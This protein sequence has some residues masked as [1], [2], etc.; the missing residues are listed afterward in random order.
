MSR[1][2]RAFVS[3][4]YGPPQPVDRLKFAVVN[5]EQRVVSTV[6]TVF[7]A[8]NPKRPDIYLTASGFHSSTKFSIHRDTL[9]HSFLAEAHAGLVERGVVAQGSRHQQQIAIPRLP[10]HG[11]TLRFV[12]ELL[13]KK[14]HSADEYKG[15]IVA[16]PV[17]PDGRVLEI[18]LLLAEGTALKVSGAQAAIGQVV[19]GGRAL[20][21]V[22]AFREHDAE[23]H[24]ADIM[25]LISRTRV[26]D[27]V[28]RNIDPDMDLVMML[29]GEES[30]FMT[31]TEVHNVRFKP[32]A[33]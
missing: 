22:L 12:P 15:T 29:Y 13:S 27:H 9:N 3:H 16:L 23:L 20:V 11:L 21:V 32:P 25:R 5:D 18:G 33:T 8:H 24:K 17:P 4:E 26:P 30:G 14:G 2:N 1:R 19:S 31:V 6:W 7:P 28:A 10:W